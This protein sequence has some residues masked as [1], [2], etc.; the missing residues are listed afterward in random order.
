L[1]ELFIAL[2]AK[3]EWSQMTNPFGSGKATGQKAKPKPAGVAEK[4]RQALTGRKA[5]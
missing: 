1:P 4:L 3:I 2:D 5:A